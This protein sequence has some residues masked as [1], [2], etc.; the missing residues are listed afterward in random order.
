M[1][2]QRKAD[3]HEK[4][5][6]KRKTGSQKHVWTQFR[7]QKHVAHTQRRPVQED[8]SV[9]TID[10]PRKMNLLEQPKEV[11]DAINEIRSIGTRRFSINFDNIFEIEASAALMLT[12]ELKVCDLLNPRIPLESR[13]KGWDP[14]VRNLLADMGFFEFM[15]TFPKVPTKHTEDERT[16][17]KF[18]SEKVEK[19][20]NGEGIDKIISSISERTD[21]GNNLYI[22]LRNL[23]S[24]A[25]TNTRQ[26]AY[27]DA[28]KNE[29]RW[30]ISGSINGKTGEIM[31]AC[32]DRGLTIP[33]TIR[34]NI[35]YFNKLKIPLLS[36]DHNVLEAVIKEKKSSTKKAYRGKGLGDIVS[37]IESS[38]KGRLA[39]FSG[40][41]LAIFEKN[42]E[43]K[44]FYTELPEMLRGTMIECRIT[45]P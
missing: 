24:E 35:N 31:I 34:N 17:I 9:K 39:I 36:P 18:I 5:H 7:E 23:M 30:W 25:V 33:A 12:A 8:N 19:K 43:T 4:R 10:L 14:Q 26:H 16:F 41:G 11:I 20:L 21:V 40:K 15:K 44:G 2:W 29:S 45:V 27:E 13:D 6:K 28:K 38:R 1:L 3:K 37:A 32:Y 22:R 42:E